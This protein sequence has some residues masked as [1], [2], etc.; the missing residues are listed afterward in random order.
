MARL[1]EALENC[2][3]AEEATAAK[4][5]LFAKAKSPKPDN[6]QRARVKVRINGKSKD[7]YGP[8]R[9]TETEFLRDKLALK[10]LAQEIPTSTSEA[11][12]AEK[13]KHLWDTRS[14]EIA[15]GQYDEQDNEE[16]MKLHRGPA[17]K[18]TTSGDLTLQKHFAQE[19]HAKDLRA[20][21]AAY[22]MGC[23][24]L[25]DGAAAETFLHD[26][27]I[28]AFPGLR[29]VG[30]TCWLNS[31]LQCCLHTVPLRTY[32]EKGELPNRRI[33]A[34]IQKLSHKYW[35][36][37]HSLKFSVLAP[38]AVLQELIAASPAFGGALQC[39]VV[40]ACQ[41]LN[42]A[43]VLKVGSDQLP[44]VLVQNGM[45]QPIVP[46]NLLE[47]DTISLDVFMGTLFAQV[48]WPPDGMPEVI[49]MSLP[50]V[51]EKHGRWH[52]TK[53]KI[54]DGNDT[55]RLGQSQ[56]IMRSCIQHLHFGAPSRR[57]RTQGH[58][59]AHV[60]NKGS[61]YTANDTAVTLKQDTTFA[62]PALLFLEQEHP[63]RQ[64][65]EPL[66]TKASAREPNWLQPLLLTLPT[67]QIDADVVL[68]MD[69]ETQT[70]IALQLSL[71]EHIDA[72]ALYE[73][74]NAAARGTGH[75][76]FD[77][78]MASDHSNDDSDQ[79][80]SSS[81]SELSESS[82]S[83]IVDTADDAIGKL[84]NT[85]NTE[86]SM[87]SQLPGG[88]DNGAANTADAAV[89][90]V[91]KP[92]SGPLDKY[93]KPSVNS[94]PVT[95]KRHLDGDLPITT[96]QPR[97][98]RKK[99]QQQPARKQQRPDR[100]QQ[101]PDRKQQQPDRKQQRPDRQHDYRA[102]NANS[103]TQQTKN[104]HLADNLSIASPVE[105]YLN[106][107]ATYRPNPGRESL[108]KFSDTDATPIGPVPC[109][110]CECNFLCCEDLVA[111]A[112]AQH[113][114][115]Q[116]YLHALLHL[117]T[118][119]PR[120][121]SPAC[122]RLMI[123]N[124]SEFH[125]RAQ[126]DWLNFTPQMMR[127]AQSTVGLQPFDRWQPR[128][129]MACICCTRMYWPEDMCK[130]HIAGADASWIAQP[131]LVWEMLSV[132]EYAK[133]WPMI[134]RDELEASSVMIAG[135]HV[136]LHKRR[137]SAE[138]L[139]GTSPAIWCMDC[140]TALCSKHPVMPK[141]AIANFNWLGRINKYQQQLLQPQALGNRL[142]LALAR[143]V[144]QK[145]IARPQK[146]N[147]KQHYVWQDQYLAKGMTATGWQGNPC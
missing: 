87:P 130:K 18:D 83:M 119:V 15:K 125:V 23:F 67:H 90:I 19:A 11:E 28:N 44:D 134:P 49:A 132:D 52:Y 80:S 8:H 5:E 77:L 71:N 95:R 21:R 73:L 9:A 128:H 136:L 146:E 131:D 24:Y 62:L 37:G 139:D 88:E 85:S 41:A 81:Q 60:R 144:T 57:S 100:K 13:L 4:A 143:A 10:R 45:L 135:R 65:L 112:N 54:C 117:W 145:I 109:F 68:C 98:G 53:T 116:K 79:D 25:T 102:Q 126:L 70:A 133:A 147:N 94:Q 84:D 7:L 86:G 32:I 91:L 6:R 42:L 137:C 2:T 113:G 3:T 61:W 74:V 26:Q 101:R 99:Q 55:I 22:G 33:G 20:A 35:G 12:L 72:E 82:C 106:N 121:Q 111:H 30:N 97:P 140:P 16:A 118:I 34:A 96:K 92:T 129:M 123:A 142:L 138:M 59:I 14:K 40:E 50:T 27:N 78:P 39:D 63:Q 108:R 46:D 89:P 47:M 75:G 105:M 17:A 48:R 104:E 114:G 141:A 127:A 107:V 64:D 43:N 115:Y 103:R 51:Y 120:K 58:Y 110:L 56:Y 66:D 1:K 93:F 38:I 124:F 31:L 69:E 36:R 122:G 76:A 29:N